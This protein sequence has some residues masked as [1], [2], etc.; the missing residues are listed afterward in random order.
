[1]VGAVSYLGC[2]EP[3][4][5]GELESELRH[6]AV[7]EGEVT[8]GELGELV[9]AERGV[10]GSALVDAVLEVVPLARHRRGAEELG[11]RVDHGAL[12]EEAFGARGEDSWGA[13]QAEQLAGDPKRNV[14][15][16]VA[17][18]VFEGRADGEA[19]DYE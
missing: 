1:L 10:L 18:L 5:A 2:C 9:V 19:F 4:L 8:S 3:E 14:V 6:A 13:E 15:A 17:E 7:V 12:S 16:F 11:G